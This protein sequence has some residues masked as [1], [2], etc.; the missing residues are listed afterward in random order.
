M[1]YL[2]LIIALFLTGCVTTQPKP[3]VQVPVQQEQ[4]TRADVANIL[5][6]A[7]G[8]IEKQGCTAEFLSERGGYVWCR[9]GDGKVK[10]YSL[11]K[12]VAKYREVK[13]KEK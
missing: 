1:K 13:A 3:E 5:T 6:V 4:L 9:C 2:L 8:D 12:L 11:D 10:R 7:I